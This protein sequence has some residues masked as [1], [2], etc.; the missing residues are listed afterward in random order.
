MYKNQLKSNNNKNNK[1]K[2]E[3]QTKR[4]RQNEKK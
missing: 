1:T 2:N 3:K 4:V